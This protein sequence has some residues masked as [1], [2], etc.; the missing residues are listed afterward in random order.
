MEVLDNDG[1]IV[2]LRKL[3]EGPAS[4]S[5]GLHAARLAGLSEHVLERA[6]RIMEHL[7]EN[8]RTIGT[9]IPPSPSLPRNEHI[10]QFDEVIRELSDLNLNTLTPLEALNCLHTWKQILRSKPASKP[11]RPRKHLLDDGPLLF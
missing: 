1:E 4:E 7:Q 10:E 11:N 9:V 5:Y 2:F 8:G 3:K 6:S